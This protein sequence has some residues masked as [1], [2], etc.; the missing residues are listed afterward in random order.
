MRTK[1][2]VVALLVREERARV[3]ADQSSDEARRAEQLKRLDG[4]AMILAKTAARDTS[5]LALLAEDAVVSEAARS[6]T[7]D[8]RSDAGLEPVP[9]EVKPVEPVVASTAA[10]RRVVPQSVVARQLANP[11]LAPDF[12][13]ARKSTVAPRRLAGWELL[14]PLFNSFEQ[15][16]GGQPRRAWSSRRRLPCARRVAGS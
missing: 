7:R 9:D 11:F 13:A 6:L 4:I 14:G 12:A 2:Q 3:E 5:L 1:F 10:E 16:G 15:A 8:M